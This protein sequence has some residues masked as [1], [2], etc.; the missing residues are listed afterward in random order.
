MNFEY[1]HSK[2][3]H[4]LIP[5]ILGDLGEKIHTA[6]SSDISCLTPIL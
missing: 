4:I 2:I 5:R 1:I 6:R 3:E